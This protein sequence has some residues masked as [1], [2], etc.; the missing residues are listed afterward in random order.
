MQSLSTH[1]LTAIRAFNSTSEDVGQEEHNANICAHK[2]L[3]TSSTFNSPAAC[4][5][6]S[7]SNSK[8]MSCCS[9]SPTKLASM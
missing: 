6:T 3:Q 5:S 4:A 7:A 9:P 8:V 1:A 2:P